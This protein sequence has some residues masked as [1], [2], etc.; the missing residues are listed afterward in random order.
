MPTASRKNACTM[1]TADFRKI[2]IYDK[3]LPSR[4][5]Y[6]RKILTNTTERLRQVVQ[7]LHQIERDNP[8]YYWGNWCAENSIQMTASILKQEA[9]NTERISQHAAKLCK[10]FR[11]IE[12]AAI[13]ILKATSSLVK[14]TP[15]PEA[16]TTKTGWKRIDFELRFIQTAERVP[17]PRPKVLARD[18]TNQK[19]HFFSQLPAE[20]RVS[21]WEAAIQR[22][23][24][25]YVAALSPLCSNQDLSR[26]VFDWEKGLWRACKESRFVVMRAY[27]KGPARCFKMEGDIMQ[28]KRIGEQLERIEQYGFEVS[29]FMQK[30]A[31][32][33]GY[34][35]IRLSVAEENL[36][37]YGIK[38]D[39]LASALDAL[40]EQSEAAEGNN[41]H[42][43]Y[44]ARKAKIRP[45]ALFNT[46]MKLLNVRL[47]LAGEFTRNR[48]G[49][50]LNVYT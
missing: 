22:P 2:I 9:L 21:I 20:L 36:R 11:K 16:Y 43:P 5:S 32:L 26:I 44:L 31:S 29:S 37:S 28:R 8:I 38:T 50:C 47:L 30:L 33:N 7:E 25:H 12:T 1:G 35:R 48:E 10:D 41:L 39:L 13:R 49:A 42:Q 18:Y 34:E 19:F 14:V 15:T 27:K 45:Q 6:A 4:L 23:C 40:Y 3:N 17:K 46:G 24:P